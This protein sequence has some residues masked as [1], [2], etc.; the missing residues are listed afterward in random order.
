MAVRFET[1]D[2]GIGANVTLYGVDGG[3]IGRRELRSRGTDC[4]ELGSSS[5]L[6]IAIAIDP[7]V[8]TRGGVDAG[9]SGES[10]PLDAGEVSPGDR[11]GHAGSVTA[12]AAG[13][14]AEA[15][16]TPAPAVGIAAGARWRWSAFSVEGEV[17]GT[18]PSGFIRD[19]VNVRSALFV[20]AVR[21]CHGFGRLTVCASASGGVLSSRGDGLVDARDSLTPVVGVGARA[22]YAVIESGAGSA[23]LFAEGFMNL[24]HSRLL[25]GGVPVWQSAPAGGRV[26]VE[27]QW[28][29]GDE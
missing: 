27:S 12:L 5:A 21:P 1:T 22:S 17:S 16:R 14:F 24:A 3:A 4:R 20:A 11:S 8:L 29:L 19:G 7:L 2:G 18:F 10:A 13:V 28:E 15:G 25:I 6:A 9:G 23:R 26:G